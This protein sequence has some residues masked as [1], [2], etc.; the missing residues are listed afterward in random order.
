MNVTIINAE[1]KTPVYWWYHE[2]CPRDTLLPWWRRRGRE[3]HC[4]VKILGRSTWLTK[5]KHA[6]SHCPF[7]G[8]KIWSEETQQSPLGCLLLGIALACSFWLL[9]ILALRR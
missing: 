6:F 8:T 1:Q 7:C 4:P 5:E 9:I 2:V 3:A